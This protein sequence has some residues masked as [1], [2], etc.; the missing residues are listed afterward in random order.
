MRFDV[1]TLFP[2]MI[3]THCNY[4]ILKRAV[5]AG[6]IEVNT[7]NPRDFTL[8]K[9]RKVDDTPYGGGAGM[10]LMPQPYVD[11]YESVKQLENSVTIMLSPQGEPLKENVVKELAKFDQIICLC[12]HYEGF[13]ER[14]RDII[15]PREISLGDF[16]LTGG[17]LPALCVIDAVSRKIEGTLGKIES[18]ED[19]SFSD[20]L[21]E[22]PQYTRPREYRG[23]KV[24]EVLLNGNHKDINEFRQ[25]ERIKRT[26]LKRPD[27]LDSK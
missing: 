27:L 10:V 7:V 23:L 22:Y 26:R 1:L 17:E 24:P 5:A 9:H 8:D 12:G 11:A 3:E 2:E 25:A 21:L 18:A 13:D 14:I 20:G 4:S 15:K 6:V 16:V 19:D